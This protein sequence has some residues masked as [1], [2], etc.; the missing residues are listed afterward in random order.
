MSVLSFAKRT[1]LY[2]IVD[3]DALAGRD[4]LVFAQTLLDTVPL[5]A[6]QLRAKSATSAQILALAEALSERCERAGTVFVLNDRPDLALLADV[7]AVHVG[8][9]DLSIAQTRL[10][11]GGRM[12]G[13]STH[14]LAQARESLVAGPD[15][16]ALGPVFATRSKHNP[17]A[18]VSQQDLCAAVALCEAHKTPLVAIGGITLARVSMLFSM[19]IRTVAVIHALTQHASDPVALGHAARALYEALTAEPRE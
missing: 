10:V 4:P 16:V 2:P 6:L 19:G 12:V 5:F 18:V 14:T 8:Q 7:R 11:S 1:G 9:D 15:Y 3:L 13:H 17:D